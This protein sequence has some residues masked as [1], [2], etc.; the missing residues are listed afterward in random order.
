MTQLLTLNGLRDA[1]FEPATC[2]R[3]DRSRRAGRIEPVRQEQTARCWVRTSELVAAATAPR[4]SGSNRTCTTGANCAMLGSNQRLV[5]AATAPGER[6]E[7][8]LY[9]RSK[10]RDAGFEPANLSPRRPLPGGAGRI[11]PVPQE[12]TARCWVRTSDL[13]PRRPLPESGSNRTCTTGANC[14]MLGSNQRLLA[15]E[16]SAL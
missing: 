15:C 12:Q 5:A 1:G 2:R 10:L 6:V 7:S 16:A 11:E 9:D 3:G 8:N 13:S 4:R 14:A